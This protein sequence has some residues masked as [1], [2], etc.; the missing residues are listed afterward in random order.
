MQKLIALSICALLFAGCH[1]SSRSK[2]PPSAPDAPTA[3][4][5]A[6][7]TSGTAP[8]TVAFTDTSTGEVESWEWD[9]GDGTTSTEQNPS[10]TFTEPGVYAVTLK[11][12]NES[13][14]SSAEIEITVEKEEE[15]EPEPEPD[16]C[17]PGLDDIPTGGSDIV[18]T[19][20][21]QRVLDD[22]TEEG[23]IVASTDFV[24]DD[25]DSF[26]LINETEDDGVTQGEALVVIVIELAGFRHHNLFGV[27]DAEDH[28]N[29]V[30]LFDGADEA[31]DSVNL[32]IFEDGEVYIN[33]AS[34]GVYFSTIRFG[35]YLDS[36]YFDRG[37]VFFSDS[38]LN[39]GGKDYMVAYQGDDETSID[40]PGE[41]WEAEVFQ[42]DEF[43][44]G[45]EDLLYDEKHKVDWDYEDMVVLISG[46]R[47]S[48]CLDSESSE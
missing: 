30:E 42:L 21:L 47:P 19:N 44:I 25:W 34:T 23:R 14:D 17:D 41:Q 22:L 46:L 7:P 11:V 15:P 40:P 24:R 28:T 10:H 13:G 18:R 8:L 36:S 27:F 33:G 9:F 29:R 31:E 35:F 1:G 2:T 12:S 20:R 45:F 4:F 32:A 48:P 16:P 37:G 3:S 39:P 26:W 6:T 38:S 5:D 43:V